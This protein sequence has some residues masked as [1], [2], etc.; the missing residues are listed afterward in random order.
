MHKSFIRLNNDD[1]VKFVQPWKRTR[2][3]YYINRLNCSVKGDGTWSID[4]NCFKE[5]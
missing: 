2:N 3:K 1:C 5:L 4:I